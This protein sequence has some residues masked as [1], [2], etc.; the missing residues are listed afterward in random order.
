[1]KPGGVE[2]VS[3]SEGFCRGEDHDTLSVISTS[4]FS[5]EYRYNIGSV[6][7]LQTSESLESVIKITWLYMEA[8]NTLLVLKLLT[9]HA[10]RTRTSA[11]NDLK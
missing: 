4:T 10:L 2:R 3:V 8:L 1:M 5:V 11:L 7:K 9:K 6:C